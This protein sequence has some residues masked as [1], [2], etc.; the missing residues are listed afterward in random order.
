MS[1][2]LLDGGLKVSI[3]YEESDRDFDDDICIQMIE[4][5]PDDEK[6]L[7]FDETNIYITPDQACL[8]ILALR[9]AMQSYRSSCKEP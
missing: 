1:I 4:D 8:L 7:K 2:V 6:I 3:F 5:C 9:R